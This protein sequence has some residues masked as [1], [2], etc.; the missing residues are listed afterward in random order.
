M[1]LGPMHCDGSGQIRRLH[2]MDGGT[3]ASCAHCGKGGLI[4][5]GGGCL[6]YCGECERK[7]AKHKVVIVEFVT[8]D[9]ASSKS[10]RIREP[11]GHDLEFYFKEYSDDQITLGLIREKIFFERRE[12]MEVRT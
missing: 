7:G 8:S 4:Q 5:P 6:V 10:L 2:F 12:G 9:D 11:S 3:A 1:M